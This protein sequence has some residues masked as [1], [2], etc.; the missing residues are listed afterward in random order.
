MIPTQ[1]NCPGC[2]RTA[3]GDPA[4][5]GAVLC[6][7]CEDRF[8]ITYPCAECDDPIDGDTASRTTLCEACYSDPEVRARMEGNTWDVPTMTPDEVRASYEILDKGTD[9]DTPF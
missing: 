3:W 6:P 8:A 2:G 9:P 1:N 5:S 7:H 4:Y